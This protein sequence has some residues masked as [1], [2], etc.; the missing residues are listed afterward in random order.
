MGHTINQVSLLGRVGQA[1]E[2]RQ[3]QSGTAVLQLRLAT[4]RRQRTGEAASDWHTVI[5]WGETAEAVARYVRAGQRV[6]VSGRLQTRSWQSEDGQ[7]RS[8]T[9]IQAREVIFLDR[10]SDREQPDADDQTPF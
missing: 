8:R 4:D 2:L 1:P 9:E 5:C 10:P 7:R 3:T 6:Y